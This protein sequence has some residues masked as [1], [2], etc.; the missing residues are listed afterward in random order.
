M[1][2]LIN[3]NVSH[4]KKKYQNIEKLFKISKYPLH[5]PIVEQWLKYGFVDLTMRRSTNVV[6]VT[7][8]IWFYLEKMPVDIFKNIIRFLI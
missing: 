6:N 1:F 7:K 5:I 8:P 3:K 2:L 4:K